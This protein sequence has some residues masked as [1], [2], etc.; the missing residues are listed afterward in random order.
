MLQRL[1]DFMALPN[2]VIDVIGAFNE[3]FVRQ[4]E[5][6][7]WL[8]PESMLPYPKE[9]IRQALMTALNHA[10]DKTLKAQ[11]QEALD[12]LDLG[13]VP[14]TELPDSPMRNALDALSWHGERRKRKKD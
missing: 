2:E 14:D 3:V 4:T 1:K 11:L 13:F 8:N 6:G 5:Q 7:S 9:R 12:W 10:D